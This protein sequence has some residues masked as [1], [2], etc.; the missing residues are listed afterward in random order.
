MSTD[1]ITQLKNEIATIGGGVDEDTRAVAGSG[2][3]SKRI[4][5][6]GGVFRKI[7]N[8]KE[9]GAIEDRHMNVIFV[10]LAHN[11]NRIYYKDAYKRG[12]KVAPTCWSSDSKVPDADVQSPMASRCE[13]C[14]M[15]VKGSG[16]N[17]MG[18]ACRLSWRTAVV[19]PNDPSG[20][21]MQLTLPAASCFGKENA[22]RYP[23]RPYVQ[24]LAANNISVGR[25]ITRMQFD[26]N[27]SAPKLVF[28][29]VGAVPPE[30][31]PMVLDQAK[32]QAAEQAVK[33]TI[34]IPKEEGEAAEAA[35]PVPQI[36]ASVPADTP[37]PK[38]RESKKAEA[39]AAPQAN[40][41][42][43]MSKWAGKKG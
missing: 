22:G 11:P 4:S 43:V 35:A 21:I 36:E 20:D 17:G 12:V 2:A 37:E 29:P 18:T 9:V 32:T 1:L 6:E 40:L 28:A 42:D 23:F 30:H 25:V 8:G 27:S 31:V 10:K 41:A 14:P 38:L 3:T 13:E 26:T 34:Y 7:V 19:L 5:I 39:A 16:S 33:L 24:M 15:S